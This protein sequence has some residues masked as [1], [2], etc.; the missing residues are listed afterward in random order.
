[1]KRAFI[2]GSC[3]LAFAF[4]GASTRAQS[5]VALDTNPP[6]AA[7]T[8]NIIKRSGTA[9]ANYNKFK[10]TT[11]AS[12]TQIS[13]KLPNSG[14]GHLS[15]GF[16]CKGNGVLR[17]ETV[18]LRIFTAA[19]D[20]I[21]VD[22]PDAVVVIDDRKIFEGKAEITDART[23]RSEVYASLEISLPINDFLALVKSERFG[24]SI[25]QSAW[26][27]PKEE[28]SKFSDLLGLF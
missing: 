17:P 3:L 5:P 12:S 14:W 6:P 2:L 19:G 1:M 22:K 26:W 16:S 25:G 13:L 28:L 23:N 18:K 10:D 21:F 11:F 8:P 4:L 20:R 24:L 9:S 7:P 15:A 27:I